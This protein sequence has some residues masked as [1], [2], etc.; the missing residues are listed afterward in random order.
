MRGQ[1]HGV[2]LRAADDGQIATLHERRMILNAAGQLALLQVEKLEIIVAIHADMIALVILE[3][4]HL[5]RACRVEREDVNA[6]G[7]DLR[8]DQGENILPGQASCGHTICPVKKRAVVRISRITEDSIVRTQG[9]I[10]TAP[11][12]EKSQTEGAINSLL[13]NYSVNADA[14]GDLRRD[15]IELHP[16]DRAIV[17]FL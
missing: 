4:A 1:L 11:I 6:F 13:K 3:K 8:V 16:A 17:V 10:I 15:L 2:I 12:F 14:R 9:A 7:V 5:Y